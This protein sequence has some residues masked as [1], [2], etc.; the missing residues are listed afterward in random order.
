M[1]HFP[2]WFSKNV[3]GVAVINK[4]HEAVTSYKINFVKNTVFVYKNWKVTHK[5]VN[6]KADASGLAA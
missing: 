4:D 2:T 1:P 3:V 6:L 5:M